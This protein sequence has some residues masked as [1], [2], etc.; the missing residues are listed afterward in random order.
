MLTTDILQEARKNLNK[1]RENCKHGPLTA[2]DVYPKAWVEKKVNNNLPEMIKSLKA[3]SRKL[4][5]HLNS[6]AYAVP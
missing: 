5:L 4:K 6:R 2:N 1:I 3:D